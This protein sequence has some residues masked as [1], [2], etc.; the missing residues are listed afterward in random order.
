MGR[1]LP[2]KRRHRRRHKSLQAHSRLSIRFSNAR[3]WIGAKHQVGGS[4]LCRD[5]HSDGR[6]KVS[7]SIFSIHF[8][9]VRRHLQ[10]GMDFCVCLLMLWSDLCAQYCFVFVLQCDNLHD[11]RPGAIETVDG[12]HG[13]CVGHYG[14]T[15]GIRS[16]DVPWHC[17]HRNKSGGTVPDD[18]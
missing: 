8:C 2:G 16:G 1:G 6:F 15:C 11:G 3:P 10:I 9:V 18:R 14:N 4:V 17:V 13:Q 7:K 12:S 5:L